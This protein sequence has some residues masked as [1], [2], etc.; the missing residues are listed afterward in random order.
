MISKIQKSWR[1]FC[2]ITIT[3]SFQTGLETT[4]VY[5]G[6][7]R[8]R[9]ELSMPLYSQLILRIYAAMN[10]QGGGG[11]TEFAPGRGKP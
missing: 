6:D 11:K 8:A 1:Q 9:V 4:T 5:A 10:G 2:D 7:C 3:R